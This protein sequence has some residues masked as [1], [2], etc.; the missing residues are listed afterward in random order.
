MQLLIKRS[1]RIA[2]NS[3]YKGRHPYWYIRN[4]ISSYL[5]TVIISNKRHYSISSS[6]TKLTEPQQL[7]NE[8]RTIS[9]SMPNA[10]PNDNILDLIRL[11]I[12]NGL[13]Q[14]SGI[15]V[16][17]IFNA[18]NWSTNLKDG[19]F[20]LPIPK[21]GI[22]T[23]NPDSTATQWSQKFPI[24]TIINKIEPK[25]PFLRFFIDQTFL[26]ENTI[27]DI[28]IK[29][30]KYGSCK[31]VENKRVIIDFSSP[32]IAKPFHA[33]HLRS[34]IIGGFLS[35]LYEKMGW[36]VI[37]MNY[38]GDWGKQFGLLAIGFQRYGNEELLA[39]DAINHLFDVYVKINKDVIKEGNS[40]FE[41]DSTNGR[42]KA[43][44]KRMEN[45]DPDALKLWKRFRD[46]SIDKYIQTY[47][48][49]NINYDIYSGESQVRKETIDKALRLFRDKGLLEVVNGATL[50]DLTN[51]DK[52][53]GKPVIQKS[54]STTLYL[55]R[56]VGAA[57]DRY[58]TYHFDKMIYV[59]GTQQ[60]LHT[61][62]LFEIL[63]QM[64]FKWANNLQ[65][66]KFG[67]IKGMSTRNGNVV[68]LDTIL[69]EAKE[70]IL[71][72]MQKNQH[73]YLQIENPE[74]VA[75]LVGIS[76]VM[77]QDMQS[78]RI[79]NYEFKWERILTFEGDTGPYLQYTHSRLTSICNNSALNV[80][81]ANFALLTEPEAI[82][83]VRLLSQYCDVL[84]NA[85]KTQEPATV[86]TYLFK[87][88]HQVSSCY[89]VL[90]VAGQP[91]DIAKA[92]L[93][94]YQA[95]KQVLCNGMHLL[96]LTPVDRM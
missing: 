73:K 22:K 89:N 5:P 92:R 96:G 69:K 23:D 93:A 76:A 17:K 27:P 41:K 64:G 61:A 48:R 66:I 67:M 62:Q 6:Q 53:L 55:T 79:N 75:D 25:G 20:I 38:L 16:P 59:I 44:F 81:D 21:L 70:R 56:D 71:T 28:L 36:D 42:A 95:A 4:S 2:F 91:T 82:T 9:R 24:D 19:D 83:L 50:I 94:L 7:F 34:T 32:N 88:A 13:C 84:M 3:W 35:N 80:S 52:K 29:G 37:R 26:F 87:L 39:K 40:L 90:W 10:H 46:L 45:N 65:H 31:I 30:D 14:V 15:E 72:V 54:D 33:G 85:M 43:F 57:M 63:K 49:L 74:Q 12:S 1:S 8:L 18:L 58:E 78:K 60:D 47:A 51:I 77:I 68:F 11:Y 86:V